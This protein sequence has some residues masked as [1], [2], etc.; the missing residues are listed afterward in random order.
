MDWL[1]KVLPASPDYIF[2]KHTRMTRMSFGQVVHI[3]ETKAASFFTNSSN[4]PQLPVSIQ[5]HVALFFL[6]FYGNGANFEQ[7]RVKFGYGAGTLRDARNRVV[8][9]LFSL[10]PDFIR[11]PTATE[12][13]ILCQNVKANYG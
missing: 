6:G 7:A 2:E 8:S 9:A 5:L 10:A 13:K 4:N 12:R 11:W 3:L 1:T